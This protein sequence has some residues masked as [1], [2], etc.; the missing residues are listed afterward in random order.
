MIEKVKI[1]YLV[2]PK[3]LLSIL[4]FLNALKENTS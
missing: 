1:A 4:L 2:R 3:S